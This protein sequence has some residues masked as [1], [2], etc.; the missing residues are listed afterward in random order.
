M[1]CSNC[2]KEIDKP[3]RQFEKKRYYANTHRQYLKKV[4]WCQ[5]CWEHMEELNKKY[6][7]EVMDKFNPNNGGN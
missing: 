6:Q 5:E 2:R 7:E 1:K 3:Y 4:N